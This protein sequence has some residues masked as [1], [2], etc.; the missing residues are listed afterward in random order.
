MQIRF[1]KEF[2]VI[3]TKCKQEAI[4][5]DTISIR[6]ENCLSNHKSHMHAELSVIEY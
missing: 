5:S 2:P 6:R 4:V 3:K 1:S